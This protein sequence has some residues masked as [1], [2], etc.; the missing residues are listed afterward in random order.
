MG[1]LH[2]LPETLESITDLHPRFPGRKISFGAVTS[3]L[4]FCKSSGVKP[5]D[6]LWGKQ[7]PMRIRP[8]SLRSRKTHKYFYRNI[9]RIIT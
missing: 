4:D 9:I 8:I 2:S 5:K 1:N 3:P 7:T 6:F